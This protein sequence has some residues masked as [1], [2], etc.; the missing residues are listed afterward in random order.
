[1][2]RAKFVIDKPD[3]MTATLSVQLTVADWRA[4]NKALAAG[5]D[6]YYGPAQRM[7]DLIDKLIRQVDQ[8]YYADED[9]AA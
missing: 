8:I 9:E 4:I 7:I 2:S 1:M 3:E 6:G 5:R